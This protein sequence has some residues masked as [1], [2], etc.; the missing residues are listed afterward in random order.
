M[1]AYRRF[2]EPNGFEDPYLSPG[3]CTESEA[4][5]QIF[6]ICGTRL[7]CLLAQ[8]RN[9]VFHAAT[10]AIGCVNYCA[11]HAIALAHDE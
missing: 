4:M 3:A 8:R 7:L 10:L 5:A 9:R 1:V 11:D 6:C 2:P